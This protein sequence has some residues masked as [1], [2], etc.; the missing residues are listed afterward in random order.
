MTHITLFTIYISKPDT[1][2]LPDTRLCVAGTHGHTESIPTTHLNYLRSDNTKYL[3]VCWFIGP[4][5]KSTA[6]L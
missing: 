3:R 6:I 1:I 5:V 2:S 4:L